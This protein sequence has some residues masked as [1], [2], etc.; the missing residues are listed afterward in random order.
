[1]STV[2]K[3]TSD[4]LKQMVLDE[5]RKLEESGLPGASSDDAKEVDADS[6]AGTL[7]H[8]IDHAKKLGL[9]EARLIKNLKRVR[10]IRNAIKSQIM[11]DL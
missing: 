5:K 11:K 10:R 3:L 2:K 1:M 8:K 4:L 7:S 6:L 9:A